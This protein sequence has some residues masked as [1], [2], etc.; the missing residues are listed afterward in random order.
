MMRQKLLSKES[1][2]D[3]F[4]LLLIV[5]TGTVLRFAHFSQSPFTHDEINTVLQTGYADVSDVIE[6]SVKKDIHPAGLFIFVHYWTK[7]FG[8]GTRAVKFPFIIFGILSIVLVYLI[9]ARWFNS[10]TGLLSASLVSVMQY[11]IMYSNIARPYASGL[12]FSLLMVWS[13]I[14]YFDADAKRKM[15]W[16]AGF[17][18]AASCCTYNHYFSFFFAGIVCA[19]G[20][21]FTS[22]K[23]VIAYSLACLC[24]VLIYLPH[25][26]IFFIQLGYKGAGGP[27]GW[28]DKPDSSF[29]LTYIFYLF[30]Y[31]KVFLLLC[32]G[33]GI[34]GLLSKNKF[35]K[36]GLWRSRII[37][38]LWFFIPFAA[39]YFYSVKV[40]PVL[41]Y[42]GLIF[43]FSFILIFLFSFLHDLKP[44]LKISFVLLILSTGILTLV[45][46]RK[47]YE[48]FY[49]Q[50]IN[51]IA[52]EINEAGVQFGKDSVDA[53]INV[54]DYFLDY[55]RTKFLSD[56]RAEFLA[57]GSASDI[58]KLK[59]I[60]SS[61]Q[62]NYFVFAS[63]RVYPVECVQVLKEYFPYTVSE[64]KGHLTE[65]FLCS[66]IPAPSK[67]EDKTIFS[68]E[69][70]F[71]E[72]TAGWNFDEKKTAVDSFSKKKYF[73]Y[74]PADEFGVSFSMPFSS[75][76]KNKNDII[77]A[78]INAEIGDTAS[79]PLLVMTLEK[80]GKTVDWRGAK[81]SEY[82]EPDKTGNIFL[83]V[84]FSDIHI[85]TKNTQ[86]KV[87]VWNKNRA[88]FKLNSFK[89]SC[90]NGN[91]YF[92]GLFENF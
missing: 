27:E 18:F 76:I 11:T 84:R 46:G 80:E 81:F 45:Y 5:I 69:N 71:S 32:L 83:S 34:F 39:G 15:L 1:R 28:L 42:S 66:K 65:I 44:M 43:S 86:L 4:L 35:P 31:S 3:F 92:Y 90:E 89:V 57:I 87:Y 70:N 88:S 41:Q 79:S 24:I 54:E 67:Q 61:S 22:G 49:Q 75:L 20:F 62:K 25:L 74:E 59:N 73:T 82:L 19:S 78:S 85:S 47:H 8:T 16:L 2:I 72:K 29:L 17:V 7:F 26:S 38:L 53:V 23:N 33:I 13:M 30:H 14:N 48:L 37:C 40:N 60:I 56:T 50:G 64:Y 55:Y 63:L 68:T 91:P 10:V 36:P 9:A 21:I 52:S 58:Y 6:L 77:N 51:K 12:F